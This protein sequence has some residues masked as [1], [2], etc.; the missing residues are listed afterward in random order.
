MVHRNLQVVTD[1]KSIML[2]QFFEILFYLF[3]ILFLHMHI[4]VINIKNEINNIRCVL[5]SKD[6]FFI[7]FEITTFATLLQKI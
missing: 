1:Y 5:K 2:V 7:T 6:G 3:L 4:I